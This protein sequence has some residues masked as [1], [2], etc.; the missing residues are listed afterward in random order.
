M[1]PSTALP[2]GITPAR[3]RT[4]R[5]PRLATAL[6]LA[7][8]SQNAALSFAVAASVSAPSAFASVSKSSAISTKLFHSFD[9]V[10][11]SRMMIRAP[12]AAAPANTSGLFSMIH[13]SKSGPAMMTSGQ[14]FASMIVTSNALQ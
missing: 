4:P 6:K 1:L 12:R 13:A 9:V 5:P 14:P 10:W 7:A 3:A 2:Y 8:F 11:S